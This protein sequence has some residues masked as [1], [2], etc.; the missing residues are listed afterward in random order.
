[1]G[2]VYFIESLLPIMKS[3]KLGTIV[4]TSTLPD[5]RGVPGWGAYGASKAALSWLMESLRAEAKQ[6]Y[7]VNVVTIKPGSVET[8]MLEGYGRHG[9]I[10]ARKAA[11]IIIEGIKK[12]KKVI[13]FPLAQVALIRMTAVSPAFAYDSMDIGRQK[14]DGYPSVEEE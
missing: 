3:Q 14:G 7:D 5:R 12:G 4:A 9:A 11:E 8:P 1:M 6:R 13:Q 10:P 2:T